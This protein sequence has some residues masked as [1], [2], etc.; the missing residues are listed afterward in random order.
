MKLWP[1]LAILHLTDFETGPRPDLSVLTG[2][3]QYSDRHDTYMDCVFPSEDIKNTLGEWVS[4]KGLKQFRIA[5]TEKYPHVTFFL[6]GGVE[7]PADKEERYLA[8]SPKVA[9]YDLQPEM[10]SSEVTEHLVDAINNV[11]GTI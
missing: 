9:T 10:S 4:S 1:L 11:M 3:A 7:V 8:P 2:F 5:E 6:N